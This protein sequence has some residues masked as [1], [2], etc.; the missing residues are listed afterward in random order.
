[1]ANIK[2]NIPQATGWV[3]IFS[4]DIDGNKNLLV[5]KKN[6]LVNNARKIIAYTLGRQ[7]GYAI[8]TISVYKAG[9]LLADSPLVLISFP[10]GDDKVRFNARFNEAS[11]DDT[12][13]ELKLASS[14]GGIFS[15]LSG[16]SVYK[17]SS[18][19]LEIE[20][21]LTINNI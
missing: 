16:L 11:F 20:W 5:D 2:E 7:S 21:I 17:S 4:I 1:M 9:V 3:R 6:A 10:A 8:D 15:E 19:Q 18:I 13:D 12:L 14:L